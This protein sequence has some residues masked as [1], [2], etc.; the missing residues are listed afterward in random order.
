M[1]FKAGL[2]IT[3]M[4]QTLASDRKCTPAVNS[5]DFSYTC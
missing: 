5:R 3:V 4:V 1:C 2:E